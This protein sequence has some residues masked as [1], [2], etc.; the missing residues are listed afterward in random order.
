MI[1]QNATYR[2]F[3]DYM[4]E[5]V[6]ET[7]RF[8]VNWRDFIIIRG[9]GSAYKSPTAFMKVFSE[10]LQKLGKP[11]QPG[12][13]LEYVLVKPKI[14]NK[15]SGMRMRDPE[16]YFSRIDTESEE[17][18]D[19]EYYIENLLMKCIEKY[20][21][22]AYKDD[23]IRHMREYELKLRTNIIKKIYNEHENFAKYINKW[24]SANYNDINKVYNIMTSSPLVTK[25]D[26][27]RPK[28]GEGIHITN[29]PIQTL[30][31][32]HRNGTLKKAVKILA[33]KTTFEK[34]YPKKVKSPTMKKRKIEDIMNRYSNIKIK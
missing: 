8:R 18:I 28:R 2:Q 1:I 13:R 27:Y 9:L 24:K 12:D 26:E 17:K 21:M 4:V 11:A 34:L 16:T 22:I 20:W 31:F 10:E 15:L 33:T 23:I 3:L 32:H 14:Y 7:L 29:R 5:T 6:V 19:V 25:I 30:L